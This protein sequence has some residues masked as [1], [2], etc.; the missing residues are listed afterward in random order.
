MMF[1]STDIAIQSCNDYVNT[2]VSNL[3]VPMSKFDMM[4]PSIF[5]KF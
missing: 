1:T 4:G 2:V 5:T 3:S